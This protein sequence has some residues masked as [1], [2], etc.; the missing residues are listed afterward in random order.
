[1]D[2]ERVRAVVVEFIRGLDDPPEKVSTSASF[3]ELGVD[4]ISTMDLL[5]K[6]EKEFGVEVPDDKLPMIVTIQDLVDFVASAT[7]EVNR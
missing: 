6:V 4:S 3:D 5:V 7:Q 1:V 2:T